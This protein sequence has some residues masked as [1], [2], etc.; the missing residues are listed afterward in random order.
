MTEMKETHL[1][2]NLE[3]DNATLIQKWKIS[4]RTAANY[5]EQGLEY[6][7]RGGRL[8]YSLESRE[9]FMNFRKQI[10]KQLNVSSI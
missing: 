5:R 7:K 1:N 2:E 6:F 8:F 9:R 4:R 10:S 3:W